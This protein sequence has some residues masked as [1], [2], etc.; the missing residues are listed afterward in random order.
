MERKCRNSVVKYDMNLWSFRIEVFILQLM[1]FLD[2]LFF[3]LNVM[4][5]LNVMF[6]YTAA[7]SNII[8][9]PIEQETIDSTRAAQLMEF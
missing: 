1:G 3:F 9:F 6:I 8:M 5:F 4:S 7:W 2:F